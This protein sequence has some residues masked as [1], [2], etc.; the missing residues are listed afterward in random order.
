M[1]QYKYTMDIEYV[2]KVNNKNIPIMVESLQTLIIDRD[3]EK[4]NMPTMFATFNLDKNLVDNILINASKNL[5]NIT[6][7]KFV[8]NDNTEVKNKEVYFR[9]QFTYI[10]SGDINYNKDIDYLT[11]DGDTEPRKDI[12]KTISIGLMK[13]QS[14]DDNKKSFNTTVLDTTMI[15][16]VN[17]VV[18]HM[19]ILIEPF[20][21]NDTIKQLIV[22]PIESVSKTLKFLNNTSV[23]YDT[24]YRFFMDYDTN[25]LIGSGGN[26]V[27]KKTDLYPTVKIELHK[28]NDQAGNVIGMSEDPTNKYYKIDV[29]VLDSYYSIDKLT[30]KKFN[31]ITAILDSSKEKANLV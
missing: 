11:A 4:K 8:A 1:K 14:I 27:I 22:P 25:Y 15:N 13:K 30:E 9:E 21:Y 28:T 10:I 24:P 5:F 23:F 18:K 31:N 20:T 6:L 17:M 26:P 16:V 12:Y 29:N 2:D 19:N 7:Y 3:Y